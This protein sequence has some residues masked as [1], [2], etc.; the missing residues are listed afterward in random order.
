MSTKC[1]RCHTPEGVAV[2][3]KGAKFVLQP[4]SYP[5]FLDVNL[6]ML[7]DIS[8]VD[9]DGKPLILVKPIGGDSHGGGEVLEEGSEEYENLK[10]LVDK[11]KNPPD[12]G[13]VDTQSIQGVIN[14]SPA[15]T[16]RKA[17]IHLAGRLP[18]ADEAKKVNSEEALDE[19]LDGL[20]KEDLF[21]ERIREMFNDSILTDRFDRYNDGLFVVNADDFPKVQDV[22]D[23][24]GYDNYQRRMIS[25]ALAR[26]PLNL[27]AYVVQQERPITEILTADYVAVN[28]WNGEVYGVG[29][30]ANPENENEFKEAKLTTYDG[31]AVP[32]AGV[33]TTGSFLIRWPTTPTNRSR[34]RAR[35]VFKSFLAFNVLK[36]SE[37]PV[38]AS[39]ITAVDN[40]TMN[41][42]ACSVCHQYI[43]PVAGF[44]RGWSENGDYTKFYVD[45]DWHNDMVS[46][47][48]NG[49]QMPPDSYDAGLAWGASQ[50]VKDPRFVIAM[51]HTVYT[52]IT[53][54]EP[55]AYPS[56]DTAADYKDRLAAWDAQDAFFREASDALI[57]DNYN[58]KTVV[59]AVIKSPYFRASGAVNVSQAK[60]ADMGSGRLL[61]PEMLNR[62][63]R[64]V[65][66][67]YW[68]Y[69][70]GDG[71]RRDMLHRETGENY[72][73]FYGGMDSNS[74]IKHLE[75]PNGTVAA[76]ASR[77]AN[78][79]ACKVTAWD[80]TKTP[81][82]RRFFP[83]VGPEI[84][85]ESAGNEVPASVT[86][87]KQNIA[88][89]HHLILGE[90]VTED[91]PE[92]QRTYQLY[93]D[94]WHELAAAGGNPDLP[95]WCRGQWDAATGAEL[96][97]EQRIYED[98]SYSLRSWQAVMT[99]LLMD[100][101]F[102]F[103]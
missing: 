60:L 24:N 45:A 69:Y 83:L 19:A 42:L 47:G 16:F 71:Y 40:P 78:E 2:L 90:N 1:V 12:C 97:E 43:D 18:T 89:L 50:M 6:K 44:F 5:G 64:A 53:G 101:R 100:Y 49:D 80:F 56:D 51:V 20:M 28:G 74:V 87:I 34:G 58:L 85:P 21:L 59:K 48:F 33:L 81:E 38:D 103:D 7:E 31:T 52:G 88:Y 93:L 8:R 22:R 84:V 25:K 68:G 46:P 39:K 102:L 73:V 10:T 30:F 4:P 66:G 95:Y 82:S 57:A 72:F 32:H 14:L 62:K 26:E 41:S 27:V 23:G 86:L 61:T 79:M 94:T 91:S 11:I 77:M 76:V 17:A 55:L 29:G 9:V 98:P 35:Q 13:D 96:P 36:I 92:V 63:I 3:E 15:Q 75:L 54:R 67:V 99:Y 65:T 37:R 70:D